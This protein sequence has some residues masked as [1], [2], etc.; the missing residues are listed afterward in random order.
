MFRDTDKTAKVGRLENQR[1]ERTE[2]RPADGCSTAE[3]WREGLEKGPCA[4]V[5]APWK[6]CPKT[7]PNVA[8]FCRLINN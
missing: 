2:K 8:V 5:G 6:R 3:A 4:W 1:G 7:A